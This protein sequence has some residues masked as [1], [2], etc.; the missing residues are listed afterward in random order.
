MKLQWTRVFIALIAVALVATCAVAQSA[1]GSLEGTVTDSS[2]AVLPSVTLKLTNEATGLSLTTASNEAG[3]FR[4]PVVPV[5]TYDLSADSKS[6]AAYTQKGVQV[7]VGSKLN[8]P[9]TLAVAG[10]KE[11]VEVTGELPIV[12]TTRSNVAST[13]GQRAVSEL[14]VNG[15]NFLDYTLLTPGVV[16]DVRSGDLSFAGQRGTLNSLTIDGTDNNNTFFGQTLGRTGSGRAPYQF[17]ED[18]VQEFQ[19]NT[20]GYSAELGRA[21][22][23]IIN[24]VTKSGTNQIHGT[25]FEF[26]RDRGMNANDPVYSLNRAFAIAQNRPLPLKPGYHFNQFGGNIGG[27][28][29]KDKLFFFFD[30]DGQRNNLGNVVALSLPATL[31]PANFDQYQTAAYNYLQQRANSYPT[32]F[33]QNVYLGKMDWIINSKHQ[34]SF[35]YNAQRFVGGALENSGAVS[36]GVPSISPLEHTGNSNVNTDSFN[37]QLTSTLTNTTVNVLKFSYQRDNE[38]GLSNSNNPEA[39]VRDSGQNLLYVGRNSFSPRETTIHRQQYGDTLSYVR[40]IHTFKMGFDIVNDHI[41]NYFPGNFS[42]AY[43]FTSL[44]DFGLSLAGQPLPANSTSTLL[45]A[46]A[47]TGTTGPR[48][49]PNMTQWGG[50]LQDDIRVTRNF[51]VNAGLRYDIQTY[52][53]PSVTNPTA[54]SASINTGVIHEDK[55]NF[56]PRL[57]FAYSPFGNNNTVIR[58]GYG[59]FYGNTPSILIGTALSNNGINVQTLSFTAANL[60]S[61]PNNVCGAPA[62]SPDCTPSGNGQASKPTI[63]AFANHYEQPLVHQYNLQVEHQLGKDMSVSV[64]YLGV[65]GTHLT[66]TRDINE[67]SPTPA[68]IQVAGEPSQVYSYLAYTQPRPLTSFSRVFQ[69]EDTASSWYNGL[70][71]T[72][73]KRFNDGFRLG[74]TYTWSHAIDDAPDATAVVPGTDDGKLVYLPTNFGFDR[75]SGLNDVRHRFVLNGEY[76]FDRFAHNLSGASRAILGGWELSGILTTQT[77]QPYSAFLNSD[78]NGDGNSRNERVPGTTRN[79][80]NLPATYS[81]DPRITKNVKVTERVNLKLIGEAF[82]VTNHFN[83]TGVKSTMF[84]VASNTANA[85]PC[86]GQA[87]GQKCLVPQTSGS[88]A[89]GL[90]S[91]DLGPRILQVAA[92]ITF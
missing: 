74:A 11:A 27:P 18:A 50:F 44:E 7:T 26:F 1:Q 19:V 57:G 3:Y 77:G 2:G 69:F 71:T 35:R 8:L 39:L 31:N 88:T 4:F 47:G 53:Q 32:T 13:I 89:F 87:V 49:T 20:N 73:N 12:E 21:G 60:P 41:L 16:R 59:M 38:P 85:T 14:P 83:V 54:L 29:I 66:R 81:F 67:A 40:G 25:A 48:T 72:F 5:G 43:T 86:S 37:M 92:K 76:D 75:S 23:A 63:Y 52:Q 24:V 28:V 45:E 68:S 51:T 90:P 22:G 61:Y 30:Y 70:V 82:N 33:N 79:T 62:V 42:G 46:F 10:Q 56:A 17:S 58:G 80:Y 84:N 6:F 78:L 55:N 64:G 91:T 15:R 34:A 65:K 9:V 36:S